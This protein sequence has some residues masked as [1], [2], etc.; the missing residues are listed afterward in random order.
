M[1][2]SSKKTLVLTLVLLVVSA[3]MAL[4]LAELLIKYTL[5]Q[6]TLN[7]ARLVSLR[8]VAESE[9]LPYELIPNLDTHHIGHTHEFDYKITTNSL[10][11]RGEEVETVKPEDSYRVLMLGDSMTFGWG[12]ENEETFSSVLEQRLNSLLKENGGGE[13]G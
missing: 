10:G 6:M 5:P 4:G 2:Q 7:Q 11:L 3:V 1:D 13:E 8:A 9:F 12:V